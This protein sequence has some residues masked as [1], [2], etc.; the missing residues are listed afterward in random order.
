MLADALL[1]EDSALFTAVRKV[2]SGKYCLAGA[3]RSTA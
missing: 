2:R 3:I 1:N